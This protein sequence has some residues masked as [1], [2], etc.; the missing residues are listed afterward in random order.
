VG[1]FVKENAYAVAAVAAV[2]AFLLGR[3][4]GAKS[5]A[6]ALRAKVGKLLK[7]GRTTEALLALGVTVTPVTP[8]PAGQE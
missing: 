8:A 5:T 1:K 4:H 3:M 6:E 7:E 2:V